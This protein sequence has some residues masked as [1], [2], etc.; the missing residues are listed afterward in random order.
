MNNEVAGDLLFVYGTLRAGG[1]NDIARIAPAARRF[2]DARVRGRLYDLGAYPA[3]LLD[4]GAD[5]VAGELYEIPPPAW[6]ALDALEEPVTP[7]RPDGEYL[8]V[9]AP[10]E[11]AGGSRRTVWVYVA[12]P[13]VLQLDRLIAGGDWMTHAASRRT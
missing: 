12:N 11:L 7:V 2:A 9:E 10:V 1:S 8:K 5:W 3:L 6:P 4:T 13:A